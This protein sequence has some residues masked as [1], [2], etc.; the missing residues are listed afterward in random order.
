MS[1]L[2]HCARPQRLKKAE[3]EVKVERRS[4]SF[5]LNLNLS[6]NLSESWR[7]LSTACSLFRHEFQEVLF[8]QEAVLALKLISRVS[9]FLDDAV[10]RDEMVL[11]ESEFAGSFIGVKVD[12]GDARAWLQR[13]SEVAEVF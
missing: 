10:P 12:D 5:H 7:S 13:R 11:R 3:V 4:D 2:V 1:L 6:L 9:H 8:R